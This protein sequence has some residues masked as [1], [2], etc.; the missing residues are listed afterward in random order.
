M[1]T[2]EYCLIELNNELYYLNGKE[3]T[4]GV[5]VYTHNGYENKNEIRKYISVTISTRGW[6]LVEKGLSLPVI[7]GTYSTA[8]G[9]ISFDEQPKARQNGGTAYSIA[10]MSSL[11]GTTAMTMPIQIAD[12]YDSRIYGATAIGKISIGGSIQ[13]VSLTPFMVQG[14][15]TG[16]ILSFSAV[17]L[18]GPQAGTEIK[19]QLMPTVTT[20]QLVQIA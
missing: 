11:L 6:V 5:L 2:N 8:D 19:D 15:T 17:I 1:T 18:T 4:P 7:T 3:H 20:I 14:E 13:V 16:W 9:W 12:V 10:I